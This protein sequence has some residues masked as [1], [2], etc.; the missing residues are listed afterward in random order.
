M[1]EEATSYRS[2]YCG[3]VSEAEVN[4]KIK[5]AGWVDSRRDHGGVIFID[6]RDRSGLLQVVV[7]RDQDPELHD[8]FGELRREYVIQVEGKLRPRSEETI[9]PNI[10]TG[11]IELE[12]EKMELLNE[13]K[14]PPF[15]LDEAEQTREDL[16]LEY[17]YLELRR[18]RLQKNLALRHRVSQKVRK[19]LSEAGFQEVETPILTRST[20]EGARDYVVPSRVNPGRFYALPQSPQLFKQLLMCAGTDRYFQIVKCFRDEDLRAD[21][22]PEFTQIDIEASFVEEKDIY[23]I[24][25]GVVK[26]AA[27][28]AGVDLP[29]PPFPRMSYE[30]AMRRFGT[31]KPDLRYE[32]ELEEVSDI[33]R[34]TE[35][36]VFKS[37][38]DSEGIIKALV[39]KGGEE[40][41]RS[42]LDEYTEYAQ[43]LG[44]K[45]LAWIKVG[46]GGWQSPIA[47]F[48][49]DEEKEELVEQTGLENGDLIFFMADQ[50]SVVNGVLSEIRRRVAREEDLIDDSH[51]L[52]WVTKFPLLEY[53]QRQGR[54]EA[55]HHPFTAPA[56]ESSDKLPDQPEEAYS[57]AYDLVWNG[58]EIGGGSIRNHQ[59][60]QQELMF[61]SLGIGEEEASEKFGFLLKALQYG[62]PPHG[63]IAFGLDRLLMLLSGEETIRNVIPFPKTQ[64][65]TD[66]LTGAPAEISVE[67]LQELHLEVD[68]LDE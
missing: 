3:R 55:M 13:A 25:E 42:R 57:R 53:N 22:Q 67:Q 40:W 29:E 47:K 31:D 58:V 56:P 36:G 49:S 46:A 65:A 39:V 27:E 68:E 30:E 63:G 26:A 43:S 4:E 6:L 38:L 50:P 7:D 34:D 32:L 21:R 60:E 5:V 52:L 1:T 23:E 11:T 66:P 33:F 28:A 12:A 16:R 17:R 41:S 20:P 9:N 59:V 2:H 61:E 54:Y 45:G 24:S 15:P 64:R 19:Y 10:E 8:L 48:L 14:T 35:L 18:S 62:A 51:E 37:V 44:A